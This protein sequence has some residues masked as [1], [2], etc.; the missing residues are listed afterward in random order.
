MRA[1]LDGSL[2]DSLERAEALELKEARDLEAYF[3]DSTALEANIHLPADWV[4]LRDGVHILMKRTLMIRSEGRCRWM[5]PPV[6]FLN[7]INL[8]NIEMTQQ[9]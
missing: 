3:F 2:R 8:L 6:R 1:V 5:E 7:R 4:L 9:A